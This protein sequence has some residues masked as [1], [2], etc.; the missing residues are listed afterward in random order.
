MKLQFKRFC[1][2]CKKESD[3]IIFKTNSRKGV[4]LKATRFYYQC[5]ECG[6]QFG[7]PI[8]KEELL[9]LMEVKNE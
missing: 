6:K 9:S 8:S 7:R 2:R 3:F 4:D 5:L 1:Y